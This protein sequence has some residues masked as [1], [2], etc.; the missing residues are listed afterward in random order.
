LNDKPGA[1]LTAELIDV[2]DCFFIEIID[3]YYI[4]NEIKMKKFS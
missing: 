3:N 2:P 1:V 4:R